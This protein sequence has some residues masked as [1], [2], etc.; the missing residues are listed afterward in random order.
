MDERGDECNHQ[1]H[2][3]REVIDAVAE[4]Q[5]GAAPSVG[6]SICSQ[7]PTLLPL[8]ADIVAGFGMAAFHCCVNRAGTGLGLSMILLRTGRILSNKAKRT[9]RLLR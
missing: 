4:R 6:K 5:F 7:S 2:D 8:T 1:E 3:G 9:G